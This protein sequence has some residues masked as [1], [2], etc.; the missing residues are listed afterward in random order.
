MKVRIFLFFW[1]AW[2]ALGLSLVACPAP[3]LTE[4]SPMDGGVSDAPDAR[5]V[6]EKMPLASEYTLSSK[7][8]FPEGVAFDPLD[9]VFY[10]GSLQHGDITLLT[11][12]GKESLFFDFPPA[13]RATLGLKIDVKRRRLWACVQDKQEK[14]PKHSVQV[15]DLQTQKRLHTFSLEAA[16]AGAS[17]NDL[18]LSS[19]G[20]AY[21]TDPKNPNL[22]EIDASQSVAKLF[23]SDPKLK[24]AIAGLGLNGIAMTPD[25][26]YLIVGMYVPAGLFR[27][28]LQGTKSV[29][30][31]T[32]TGASFSTPDG[33]IFL[34]QKLYAVNDAK[35][36]QITFSG[37][38]FAAGVAKAQLLESG[39]STATIAEQQL[40]IV[41]SEVQAF[42]TK[43]TPKLPFKLLRVDLSGF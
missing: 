37:A 14:D 42:V 40:Y 41:K 33:L 24:P 21:V 25:Q 28:G 2:F 4:P 18:T 7:D 31:I 35:V 27:I 5:H 39:L 15:F 36:Y 29:E 43:G 26:K 16:L 13:S 22:Y 10:L 32:L 12:D 1:G 34:G 20:I 8:S 38:D 11:R 3:I 17:C 19:A 30:K 6:P 9:G 23:L